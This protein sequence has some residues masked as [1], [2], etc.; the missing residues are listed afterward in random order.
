MDTA[1]P[2]DSRA[3]IVGQLYELFRS[4]GYE[5]VS[6]GDVSAATGLGRS[7]L[8]HYFPAGKEEMAQAVVAFA[9]QS[10]EQT[11]LAPLSRPGDLPDRIDAM[12]AAIREM[13]SGG[14][15]PCVLASLL[16]GTSDSPL[17]RGT[18]EVLAEWIDGMA[19]ALKTAGIAPREATARSVAA[20]AQLQGAIILTRALKRPAIFR[21]ALLAARRTLLSTMALA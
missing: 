11:V 21:D 3:A 17:S 12:L 18:A 9:R 20:L 14:T 10:V 7:S 15:V 13:Y 2:G 16:V 4:K 1:S 5:G 19:S 8:Y 6:I